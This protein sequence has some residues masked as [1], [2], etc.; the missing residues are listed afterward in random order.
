M[1]TIGDEL[2]RVTAIDYA[3][4]KVVYDELVKPQGQVTD[5]KTQ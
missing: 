2:T 5:Y 1:T 4:G 3:T